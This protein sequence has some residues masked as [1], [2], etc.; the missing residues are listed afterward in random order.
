MFTF[1]GARINSFVL[2]LTT[3]P[4]TFIQRSREPG[5]TVEPPQTAED[6][7]MKLNDLNWI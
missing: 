3:N 2:N 7:E 1:A 4:V 6:L 5:G